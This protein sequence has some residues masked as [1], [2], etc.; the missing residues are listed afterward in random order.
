MRGVLGGCE[1]AVVNNED[2]ILERGPVARQAGGEALRKEV[3][4]VPAVGAVPVGVL[5]N[6]ETHGVVEVGADGAE[7]IGL[8]RDEVAGSIHGDVEEISLPGV[9]RAH[10]AALEEAVDMDL[11]G[12]EVGV[13]AGVADA[14]AVG[15]AARDEV[16]VETRRELVHEDAQRRGGV[17]RVVPALQVRDEAERLRA[18]RGAV[19]EER[20]QR[21][22]ERERDEEVERGG[23]AGAVQRGMRAR[24]FGVL[25]VPWVRVAT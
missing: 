12:V 11:A 5:R 13:A 21:E 2:T 24:V 16:G 6:D 8:V 3:D 18:G 25:K 22:T 23:R 7:V 4:M 19:V 10:G 9:K 15:D 17:G 14:G 20:V 1:L